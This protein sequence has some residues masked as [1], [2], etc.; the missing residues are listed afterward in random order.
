[1]PNKCSECKADLLDAQ[2]SMHFRAVGTG[3][4]DWPEFPVLAAICPNC[5]KMGLHLATPGQ[6][7]SW[8]ESETK[9][10]RSAGG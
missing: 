5:G 4:D 9:K 7:K 3:S 6:F 10:A 8:L 1:M 2:V